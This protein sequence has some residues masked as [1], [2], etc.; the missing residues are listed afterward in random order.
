M[1]APASWLP[2]P[3]MPCPTKG[4]PGPVRMA[5]KTTNR[6]NSTMSLDEADGSRDGRRDGDASDRGGRSGR[7]RGSGRSDS[8][9]SSTGHAHRTAKVIELVGSSRTSFE[10]AVECAL[11]DARSTTRG[12]NGCEVLRMSIKCDDGRPVEYH[13]DLKLVFGVEGTPRA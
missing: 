4:G 12:I 9:A 13:V 8:V 10:D 11:A 5:R 7:T 3:Q 2:G 1:V 6:S